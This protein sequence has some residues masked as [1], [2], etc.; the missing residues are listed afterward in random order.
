MNPCNLILA[1]RFN[2]LFCTYVQEHLY[3]YSADKKE[4]DEK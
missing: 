1:F 4:I 2:T 3:C